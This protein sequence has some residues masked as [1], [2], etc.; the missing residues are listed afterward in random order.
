M[1]RREDQTLFNVASLVEHGPT[2]VVENHFAAGEPWTRNGFDAGG[3]PLL[4]LASGI[5]AFAIRLGRTGHTDG[6][7]E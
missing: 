3:F 7:E 5:E 6:A 1:K 4:D 2:G